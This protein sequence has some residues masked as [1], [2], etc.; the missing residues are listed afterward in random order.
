MDTPNTHVQNKHIDLSKA[1]I[2]CVLE[3]PATMDIPEVACIQSEDLHG[4]FIQLWPIITS[5]HRENNLSV[6]A[7]IGKTNGYDLYYFNKLREDYR[8]IDITELSEI[9]KALRNHS[10]KR[11]LIQEANVIAQ[12][13]YNGKS[14]QE[15]ALSAIKRLTPYA[16]EG[17]R[18]F[19]Q[20]RD[21]L[22]EVYDEVVL[23][24][25]NPS[26]VWGIPY[27]YYPYLSKITGGKQTG[28]L[29]LFAGEPKVGKSWWVFQDAIGTALNGTPTAV[30]CGEMKKKQMA[31]RALQ[32]QGLNG[33][34][35]KTG[36]MNANDWT[37]LNDGIEALEKIPL[38]H[39]DKAIHIKDIYPLFQQM[40][41]DYGVLHWVLDYAYLID[42][43]GQNEIQTTQNVSREVKRAVQEADVSCTLITSVN[44]LGMDKN[45]GAVKSNV[46]GSGQQIHDADLILMLTEFSPIDGDFEDMKIKPA[47]YHYY[48]TLHISAGRELDEYVPGGCI[49][50]KRN[51]SP[52]F[53]E[54]KPVE[55]SSPDEELVQNWQAYT[56]D[57]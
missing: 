15:I 19:A 18:K 16:M 44:K 36:Y 55:A 12:E 7:L 38:Y 50:Y 31:R 9:V 21:T 52:F 33:R 3:I 2:A 47:E 1:L 13:S 35:M 11:K 53:T 23:R 34:R 22:S 25:K 37:V 56:G 46:R 24:S 17:T 42:A 4:E 45:N 28:E 49:H 20:L 30:W 5:L 26:E 51:G 8:H 41:N 27:S 43:P 32:L 54:N 6:S 40:K 29:T 39:D 48:S 10:Q 14:A 57:D